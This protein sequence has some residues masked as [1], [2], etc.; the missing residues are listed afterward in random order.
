MSTA[1]TPMPGE[2]PGTL[3]DDQRDDASR[4]ADDLDVEANPQPEPDS[5]V[6]LED[7][8]EIEETE[9]QPT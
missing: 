3:P 9:Q 8:P 4:Q 7:D 5:S 1:D 6:P 2:D